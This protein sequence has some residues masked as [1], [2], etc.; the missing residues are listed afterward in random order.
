[1]RASWMRAACV[2]V[3]LAIAGAA[4]GAAPAAGDTPGLITADD[5]LEHQGFVDGDTAAVAARLP[6]RYTPVVDPSSGRPLLFVRALRCGA[7]GPE[8]RAVPVTMASFGVAIESPD[9]AGC[10]SALLGSSGDVPQACNW[11]TLFWLA[12]D[13]RVVHWLRDG[14]PGFPALYVPNLVFDLGDFDPARGGAAFHFQAPAPAPSPFSMDEI[15]RERPGE[16]SVRGGYWVDTAQ[17]TVKLAFSSD[18]L[19]SGDASGVVHA[20]PGSEMATLLGADE[21]SYAPGYSL[22]AAERW[23]HATYR[24]QILGPPGG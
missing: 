1:M 11:Y 17:G 18:D 4:G 23:A 12:N 15:A 19:T 13:K 10:S 7:V 6:K 2:T 24:K 16:L 3:G 14:T 9:G 22:V 20:E 8:G 5:C 21:R